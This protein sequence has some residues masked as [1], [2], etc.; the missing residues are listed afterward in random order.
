MGE[1]NDNLVYSSSW[2]FK[3]FLHAV[4]YYDM[5]PRDLLPIRKEG[6]LRIVIALKLHRLFRV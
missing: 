4:K 1:G 6:V 5:G 3:R 2:D